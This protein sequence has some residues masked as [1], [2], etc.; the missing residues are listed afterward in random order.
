MC[1]CVLGNNDFICVYVCVIY[2]HIVYILA[3]PMLALGRKYPQDK[4][5][6]N[7]HYI[8]VDEYIIY[9]KMLYILCTCILSILYYI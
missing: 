3:S 2:I 8:C 9:M 4:P 7:V 1:V 6:S 5:A